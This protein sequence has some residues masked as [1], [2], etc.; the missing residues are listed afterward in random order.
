MELRAHGAV[1]QLLCDHLARY[2]SQPV[3]FGI[4]ELDERL[5]LK[6]SLVDK[7][8]KDDTGT[9]LLA[10]GLSG[11]AHHFLRD[12]LAVG[13]SD[14][15]L[16]EF[17][18]DGLGNEVVKAQCHLGHIGRRDRRLDSFVAICWEHCWRRTARAGAAVC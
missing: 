15:V 12:D 3:Q 4:P 14:L 13:S 1:L 11:R 6:P 18:R 2:A 17:A 9:V 5:M 16:I 10:T 8:T 7:Q